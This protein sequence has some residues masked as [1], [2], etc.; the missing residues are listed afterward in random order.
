MHQHVH[1]GE[2]ADQ[3]V[4]VQLRDG[5]VDV[6]AARVL[7]LVLFEA[8]GVE[9]PQRWQQQR[10]LRA[11]VLVCHAA[12]IAATR[13]PATID[14]AIDAA[15]NTAAA[16]SATIDPAIDPAANIAAARSASDPSPATVSATHVASVTATPQE[17]L[18]CSR[19][20]QRGRVVRQR[21]DPE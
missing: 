13:A 14:P 19:R 8:S 9:W 17:Q 2:H 7:L 15:A 18:R 10:R 21:G 20:S 16:R 3:H 12:T 1:R 6:G 11:H 4:L 5:P